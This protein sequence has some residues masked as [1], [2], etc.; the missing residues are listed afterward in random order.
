MIIVSDLFFCQIRL[1][2]H[3][4]S[5]N[6]DAYCFSSTNSVPSAK[7]RICLKLV[8][9]MMEGLLAIMLPSLRRLDGSE[10]VN[11]SNEDNETSNFFAISG[12]SNRFDL[13]SVSR[14]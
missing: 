3:D 5:Y 14:C 8:S 2:G 13:L 11:F 9:D 4:M 12:F 6:T 1:N 10:C 7:L